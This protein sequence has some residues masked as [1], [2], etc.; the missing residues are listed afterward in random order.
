MKSNIKILYALSYLFHKYKHK[1][2]YFKSNYKNE[3][4]N[5]SFIDIVSETDIEKETYFEYLPISSSHED[6]GKNVKDRIKYYITAYK[7]RLL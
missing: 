3:A 4:E 5:L 1:I 7:G 2:Y 6:Y